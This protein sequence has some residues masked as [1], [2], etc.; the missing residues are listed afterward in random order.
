[1]TRL[2]RLTAR[3]IGITILLSGT[4][5]P[6]LA[7]AGGGRNVGGSLLLYIILAPFLLLYAWYIN[8]RI[9]KK[10]KA[11]EAL[12]QKAS[13]KD[14]VWEESH[15]EAV[16]RTRFLEIQHA[17]CDQDLDALKQRL[18]PDLLAQW[19]AQIKMQQ[20][21]GQSDRMDGLTID[22][23]RM[24]E[25]QDYRDN[26]RD[27]FSACI[28]ASAMDYTVDSRGNVV[29]SNTSSRRKAAEKEPSTEAF[30]EFWTF[31][32]VGDDWLLERIDQSA[33]WKRTVDAP[34]VDEG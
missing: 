1:M 4:A 34:L 21:A 19:T 8:R 30:R 2:S 15:L 28:D 31:R 6:L 17:W 16:V 27:S 12:L 32:R 14:P 11:A 13:A 7:R 26:S 3:L 20:S 9:N 10:R 5:L 29:E 25:V 33:D 22:S 23:V 18:C 24:V